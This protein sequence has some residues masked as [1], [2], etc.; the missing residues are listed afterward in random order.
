MIGILM[1]DLHIVRDAAL[2]FL[3]AISLIRA[4]RFFA[5][6]VNALAHPCAEEE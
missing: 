6:V 1:E 4:P 5:G 3:A 2:I